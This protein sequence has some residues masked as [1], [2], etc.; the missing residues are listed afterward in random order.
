MRPFAFLLLLAVAGSALFAAADASTG[1]GPGTVVAVL[2]TGVAAGPPELA[3]RVL[4]GADLV[5]GGAAA[6]DRSGH[7]TAVATAV[8]RTCPGCRILPVRVLSDAG[9]APWARVAEGIVWA[10]DHGARVVNLSVAGADGAPEL[11]D[12]VAYARSRDVLVVAAAGNVGDD[13]EQYPAAYEGVVAVSATGAGGRLHDWSSRGA[14]VDVAAPG[15]ATLPVRGAGTRACGTS[16]AAPVVAGAAA[17]ARGADP[18]APATEIARR[19]PALVP[20]AATAVRVSVS[21]RAAVGRTVRASVQGLR[22]EHARWFRCAPGAGPHECVAVSAGASYR[23]RAADRGSE[24]LAR[25]PTE[26]FGGLWVAASEPLPV[27]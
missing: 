27:N 4:P 1:V 6:G 17:R 13:R 16:F 19:L 20:P 25:V 8:A 11:R 2:D 9:G 5:D 24:L 18:D 23:V 22:G 12:A 3:G 26:P 10:V 7:G 15:C 21:G 14:W